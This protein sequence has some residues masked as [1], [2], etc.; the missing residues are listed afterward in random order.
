MVTWVAEVTPVMRA[1]S[2]MPEPDIRAPMSAAVKLAVAELT[3]GDPDVVPPSVAKRVPPLSL[4]TNSV[5]P[6]AVAVA[7]T[8]MVTGVAELTAV[9]RAPSGMPEPDIRA[10]MSAAVKL[11]V[12]ELTVGDPDVVPPSV[13]KRVP[14]LSLET[15]S[16]TPVAVA[17]AL[18]DMVTELAELTAV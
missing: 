4:E 12:A 9:M 6:V 8:D 5:T 18:T 17:V 2:G 7:L 13:A 16:V 14:P 15:N 10:P 3:V 1:P 11:A